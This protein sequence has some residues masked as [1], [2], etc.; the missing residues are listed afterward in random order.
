MAL[1][2]F[3]NHFI[4]F[5]NVFDLYFI[6]D[7]IMMVVSVKCPILIF[8]RCLKRVEVIHVKKMLAEIKIYSDS[9]DVETF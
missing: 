1:F 3:K 6:S 5:S 4:Q 8:K 9:N 7:I 2:I